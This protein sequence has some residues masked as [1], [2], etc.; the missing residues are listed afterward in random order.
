MD[1]VDVRLWHH[2]HVVAVGSGS[3]VVGFVSVSVL[4]A[5]RLRV[6]VASAKDCSVILSHLLFNL[7][8][9]LLKRLDIASR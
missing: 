5:S 1:I 4:S 6:R 2:A 8:L 7:T 3:W 9:G